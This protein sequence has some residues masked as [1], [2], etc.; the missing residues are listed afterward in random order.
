MYA[1]VHRRTRQLRVPRGR[2]WNRACRIIKLQAKTVLI[3]NWR[4]YLANPALPEKRTV[5]AVRPCLAEWLDSRR[6]GLTYRATQ[7]LTGH[8]CFGEYLCRIGKEAATNCHHCEAERDT[9]QH[10]LEECPAWAEQRRVLREVVGDDLS[11]PAIVAAMVGDQSKWRAFLT[12]CG[13]VMSAKEEAE[14]IRRGVV[15]QDA[16]DPPN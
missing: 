11:L 4:A 16:A 8:G 13:Q 6:H 14:R 15:T 9:A 12:F 1:E 5:D 2:V 7:V 10:T 3:D